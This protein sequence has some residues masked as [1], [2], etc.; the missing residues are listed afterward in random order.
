[1]P[2]TPLLLCHVTPDG[3]IAH[4]EYSFPPSATVL[5]TKCTGHEEEIKVIKSRTRRTGLP[6]SLVCPRAMGGGHSIQEQLNHIGT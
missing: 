5:L 3:R 2:V 4:V 1:M 6:L